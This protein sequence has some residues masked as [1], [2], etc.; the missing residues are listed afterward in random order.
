MASDV[1]E[2]QHASNYVYEGRE[3]NAHHAHPWS[4][5]TN[6]NIDVYLAPLIDD[7]KDLWSEGID[8]YDSFLKETFRLRALLM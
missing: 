6:N 2:L 3:Y 1:T 5:C 8:V 7:L 4:N